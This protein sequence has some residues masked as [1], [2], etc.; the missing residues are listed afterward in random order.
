VVFNPD[1]I[2]TTIPLTGRPTDGVALGSDGR[3]HVPTFTQT[4]GQWTYQ[5]EV[6]SIADPSPTGV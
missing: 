4:D 1:G 3:V 5:Q 6:I 2:Y